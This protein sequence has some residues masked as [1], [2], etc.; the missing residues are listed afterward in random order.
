MTRSRAADWAIG[1]LGMLL[2][3]TM[4]AVV[5]W[6][7]VS[8]PTTGPSE[9]PSPTPVASSTSMDAP[10]T[11]LGKDEVWLGDMDVRADIVVLPDSSLSDVEATGYGARSG[12]GGLIVKRLDVQAT[13]PFTD[14]AAQLGGD[15]QVSPGPDGQ[16]RIERTLD[17]LGRQVTVVATGT[18]EV[19][20]GLLVV[21]PLFIDLGGPDVTSRALAAVV[22]K[23]V[24]IEQPI[25]GLPQNL[26]LR[27]VTVQ[28]D[29]FR[30][31]L[32]GQNVV[33]AEG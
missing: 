5:L 2:L 18:V 6:W 10:P 29:G 7:V 14:V 23:F 30:A 16:A 27:D 12:P 9:A 11:D 26:I 28:E 15:T 8:E 17:V 25:E 31:D 22:R 13:V 4:A 3:L 24:T 19:E 1:A 20:N 21:E 32:S 33:L